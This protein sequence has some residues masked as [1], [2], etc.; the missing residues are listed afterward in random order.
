MPGFRQELVGLF[1]RPVD[2]N[3]TQAMIEAGFAAAGLDWRYLTIEVDPDDLGD[4]V[5]GAR[6]MGL[7]GF[8]CTIPHKVAVVEHLDRLGRSAALMGAV[9][10]VVRRGEELVGENTDGAGFLEAVRRRRDPEGARVVMLGAG[11]AARA[12]A[13]ELLLAGAASLT[14]VNRSAERGQEL[15]ALLDGVE[16][17]TELRVEELGG[18]FPVPA[19]ADMVVNATSIGLY[20]DVDAVVPLALDEVTGRAL[21]ADVIPN[22]PETRFL[23]MAAELGCETLDGLEMLVEQGRIGFELWTGVEP[24]VGVM[25]DALRRAFDV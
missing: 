21:V 17:P 11:G 7:R 10:C 8:N 2:E 14:I 12:I 24:D 1:G 23:R 13:V 22:P 4:A 6:A 18:G 5:R 15:R 16:S 19:D 3:P 9:N 25:R 20:P